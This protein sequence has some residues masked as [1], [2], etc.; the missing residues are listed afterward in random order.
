MKLKA[1]K[2]E[3]KKARRKKVSK[4]SASLAAQVLKSRIS[5]NYRG[6]VKKIK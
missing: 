4:K 2:R 1:E 3:N 6:D 5:R